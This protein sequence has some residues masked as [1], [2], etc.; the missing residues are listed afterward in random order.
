[1]NYIFDFDGTLVD[2][3]QCSLLATQ[4]AFEILQLNI[5]SQKQIEYY[6]GIPIEQ[7]FSLMADRDLTEEEYN[8]LL[9][10]FRNYYKQFEN[11]TL[12]L[13]TNIPAVLEKLKRENNR[14][15]VI[16]SKK[17]DVLLRNLQTLEIDHYFD[18]L[19]GSDQ[20][21]HYKPHPA[22]ILQLQ[23]IHDLDL[24]KSIMIGDAI[25][26][27]QM[28]AAAGCKTCAV[29][30]GSHSKSNL[31]AQNPTYCIDEVEE[32]LHLEGRSHFV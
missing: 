11:Q 19:I 7:S 2:S 21:S 17:S 16:S 32:L 29:T 25:F 3:K 23:A 22:G 12:V 4:K 10:T 9:E 20:V 8:H 18:N 27:I 14:L 31:L 15:F 26:D 28:G 1:M 30:W 24:E 5:P 13:F 6:M